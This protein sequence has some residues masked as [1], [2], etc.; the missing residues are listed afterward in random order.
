[1]ATKT[2]N[3]WGAASIVH[4]YDRGDHAAPPHIR[5]LPLSAS[6]FDVGIFRDTLLPSVA[7][8]SSLSAVAY[9]VGRYTDRVETK[10]WLWPG[11]QI[12]NA[13]WS[14][15]GRRVVLDG[16]PL[17]GV[18]AT[19][20][21][22]ERLLL[23]GVTLWGG[24]L[25][26]RLVSRSV[27][28]GGK[29]DPRYAAAKKDPNFW[30]SALLKVYIPEALLQTIIA[31]PFTAP[32]R[33]QGA[34][35]PGGYHPL[36][37]AIAVGVFSTG[38]ALEVLADWQ[39]DKHNRT[40][41]GSMCREGVWSLVRHP[42]YLGDALVHL[43]FP[44]LLYASDMLAPIEILGPVA[45]YYFLKYI[46]GAKQADA[47]QEERYAKEDVAKKVDYDEYKKERNAF[48]PDAGQI[49]NKWTWIVLGFGV[50]G[51]VVERA[52]NEMF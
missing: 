25:L 16:V 43:S 1:M 5:H 52:V 17:G 45:N 29:D 8:H 10:D 21:R 48:W 34:V 19:L 30:N 46:G 7:L 47:D 15:V 49:A 2:T 39:L 28:R 27:R 3:P 33:H 11:A 20:S 50:A 9:A 13:W 14:S 6:L 18:V 37:Q 36:L 23:T 32:F 35:L 26:Y 38:F 40:Q 12:V 51:A 31:L 42:N 44:I 22:P 4:S 24:R 41:A